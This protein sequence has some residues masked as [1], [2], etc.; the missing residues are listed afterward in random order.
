MM[1]NLCWLILLLPAFIHPTSSHALSLDELLA[2]SAQH[3]PKI[4]ESI[5]MI[6]AQTGKIQTARGAFDWELNQK[7][8]SRTSGFYDGDYME[9]QLT[10]RLSESATRLYGGYRVSDGDFPVY[11]DQNYTLTGGE[12]NAGISMALWRDRLIDEDRFAYKD[13]DLEL[14]QKEIDLLLTR[15]SVQYDAMKAYID[16]IAAGKALTIAEDLLKLSLERQ[17][18]FRKRVEKGDLAAIY[19]TENQQYIAKR[20]ADVNDAQRMLDN[21]T[22]RLGLYWRDTNG[23]MMYPEKTVMPSEFPETAPIAIDRFADVERARKIRPELLRLDTGLKREKNKLLLGEN[24][25][26]PKV[27]LIAESGRDIGNGA[28]RFTGTESKIGVNISIPLQQN[29]G[30]GQMLQSRAHITQLEQQKRLLN[31][32][33]ET[34]IYIAANNFYTAAKNVKQTEQEVNASLAME[35]AERERFQNGASDLFLVN[36]REERT[37]DAQRKQVLSILSLWHA[38]ADYYIASFQT[39][40]LLPKQL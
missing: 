1:R 27:D 6:E 35:K 19:L 34:D 13:A 7:A 23:N 9:S 8:F 39:D 10:R 26:L 29:V 18:G 40:R 38:I 5:A 12:F 15:V 22:A 37:A 16:W 33:I 2:S 24:R 31:D 14:Q 11:E 28:N 20:Q 32:K 3:Y 30:K 4:A 21:K 25:I 17:E 36:I